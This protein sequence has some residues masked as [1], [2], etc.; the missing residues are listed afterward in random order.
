LLLS[1]CV[2]CV[3]TYTVKSISRSGPLRT[4]ATALVT[5]PADGAFLRETYPGSGRTTALAVGRAFAKRLRTVDVTPEVATLPQYLEQAR[6]GRFDYLVVPTLVHWENRATEW[7]GLPD[8]IEIEIR[9][10][11][12]QSQKTLSLGS[13]TG[14]SRWMTFGGDAPEDLL[15][16]PID[17]YVSWLFSPDGTPLQNSKDIGQTAPMKPTGRSG[18]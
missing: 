4:N 11:D 7:S 17:G 5:L 12:V 16:S 14:K 18:R 2:G 8:R 10:V 13:V 3:S 6:A 9:T 15:A 1:L